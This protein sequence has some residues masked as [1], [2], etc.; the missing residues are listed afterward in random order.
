MYLE[1]VS[2]ILL[3]YFVLDEAITW[4]ILLGGSLI[5]TSSYLISRL[6]KKAAKVVD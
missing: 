4:N 6:N 3:G 1:V 2:A 5:V